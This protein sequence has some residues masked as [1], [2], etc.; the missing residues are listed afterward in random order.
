MLHAV[1]PFIEFYRLAS[2]SPTTPPR[3]DLQRA[4]RGIALGWQAAARYRRLS[5]MN[6]DE[7]QRLG[8]DRASIG[9][10]AFFGDPPFGRE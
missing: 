7:L 3:R 5:L 1:R 9:R 8:L 2:F 4:W 10:H 6:N